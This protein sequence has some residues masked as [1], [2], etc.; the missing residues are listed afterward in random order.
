[1]E[2]RSTKLGRFAKTSLLAWIGFFILAVIIFIYV[3]IIR[4]ELFNETSSILALTFIASFGLGTL[5]FLLSIF[6]Y[7]LSQQLLSKENKNLFL[8]LLKTAIIIPFF[9]LYFIFKTAI[10]YKARKPVLLDVRHA[11]LVGTIFVIL[12]FWG[13]GYLLLFMGSTRVMGLRYYVTN[14][15]AGGESMSPTLPK[16]SL[17]RLY[18]YKNVLY[19]INPSYAYKF[20]HGDI[21]SF[22]N[23][24]TKDLIRKHG[25]NDYNFVKRIIALPGD[26]IEFRGGF[27]FLN[28]QP[29]D[30]P[31][32]LTPN[33]TFSYKSEFEGQTYGN[34]LLECK[35]LAIPV[36][37]MFVLAD[38][39]EHGDD[40][41]FIGLLDFKDIEA[42]LS[43]KDQ[44]E[45]YYEGSNFI[46]HSEKWRNSD[47]IDKAV[48]EK[49]NVTCGVK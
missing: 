25:L 3:I 32:T 49:A 35:P 24:T 42:Y 18:P 33:S 17:F 46:K 41:R 34:F 38:N 16:D 11:L 19:Q 7:T 47:N 29:L 12:P 6:F 39:R 13:L 43:L 31:Y 44:K 2:D 8:A 4:K 40:S 1:M 27:V 26:T 23:Q 48:L 37:K 30:E 5:S 45:G 14:L 28:N 22:S 15:G 10:S 36:S 9:P 20:Q 21:V